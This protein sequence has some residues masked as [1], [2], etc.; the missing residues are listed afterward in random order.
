[1][2]VVEYEMVDGKDKKLALKSYTHNVPGQNTKAGDSKRR[3][4]DS[5]GK[6]E[7]ERHIRVEKETRKSQ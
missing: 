1:V 3:G 7:R 2:K 4:R 5:T 6:G